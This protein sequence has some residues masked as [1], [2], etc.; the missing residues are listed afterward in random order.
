MTDRRSTQATAA[1]TA[2]AMALVITLALFSGVSQL[3]APSHASPALAQAMQ[4][5]VPVV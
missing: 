2:A 4:L 1:A 3:A 5:Q